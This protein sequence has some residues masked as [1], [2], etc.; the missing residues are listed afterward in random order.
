MVLSAG[1]TFIDSLEMALI[2]SVFF[3]FMDYSLLVGGWF[4]M[5]PFFKLLPLIQPSAKEGGI[6][7]FL[8]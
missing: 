2:D 3:L 4:S 8:Q 1:T 7:T 6:S 5:P